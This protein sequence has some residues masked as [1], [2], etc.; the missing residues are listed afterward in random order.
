MKKDASVTRLPVQH[1]AH[2]HC[3]TCKRAVS[4]FDDLGLTTSADNHHTLLA[5]TLHIRCDCGQGLDLRKN[6]KS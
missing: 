1:K 3:Q 5:I 4:A 6:V 2:P